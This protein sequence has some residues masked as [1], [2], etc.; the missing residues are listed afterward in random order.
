MNEKN[1]SSRRT[2]PTYTLTRKLPKWAKVVKTINNVQIYNMNIFDNIMSWNSENYGIPAIDYFGTTITY[3]DLPGRVKEYVNG[4]RRM[5]IKERDVITLCMPV[6]IENILSLFALN[7]IGA[8]S[9]TPNFLFL[10][11]DFEEYTTRKNSNCLIILDAYLPFVIDQIEGSSIAKVIITR[12]QDYLPE[13]SKHIFN[14]FSKLPEK[15]RDV[16]GNTK[17]QKECIEKIKKIKSVQFIPLSVV[18]EYGKE[19][20]E[21]LRSQPVDLD[22]DISYSYTSG[23]TKGKPKC[24]VYKE[25][26]ANAFI[27]LHKG[28]DTKDYVGDRCLLVIPLTHATGERVCCYQPLARGKTLVLQPIYNKDSFGEDLY[29]LHCNWVT[30]AP[31]FYLSAIAKGKIA[32]NALKDLTRPSSGGEPVTKSQVKLIDDWLSLNGCKVR[33]AIGGGA[34]EDGSGTIFTYFMNEK[35]KTNETGHPIDPGIKVKIVNDNGVE[36]T[37]GERG[38]L[39]VSSAAAADRY[40]GDEAAT[41]ARWY[42]DEYGTRWGI[43]GDIAVQNPDDSYNILG[44]SSDSYM[45]DKGN[46]IYLF[47]IE[48]SLEA[49]DPIIEWEI[50][51]HKIDNNRSVVVG[52]VVIKRE[53]VGREVDVIEYMA[54]KYHLDAVKIYERFESS[55]VT[56]KRDFQKLQADTENYFAP[57]DQSS[58]LLCSYPL[59]RPPIRK[60]VPKEFVE[61][62]YAT[63]RPIGLAPR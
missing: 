42:F 10:K 47:D 41:N 6:S 51:A 37:K 43:T 59:G 14:D 31:S 46:R 1:G 17:K 7:N 45:D 11:N 13:E 21:P 32:D 54:R 8:I 40:L 50:T 44:R 56:G 52:Q 49:D 22:R 48:Y 24:I 12:L 63:N 16:F 39:H 61:R 62:F 57:H 18:L 19:T 36:V 4:F 3:G 27:E 29:R 2:V 55:E 60:V 15:L 9:N 5:G 28:I 33:F 26:S 25:A 38:F 20:D 30:A 35:T 23:T 58:L 53:Y 34:A